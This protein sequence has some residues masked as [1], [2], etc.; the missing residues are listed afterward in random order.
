MVDIV[1]QS[2]FEDFKKSVIGKF[3]DGKPPSFVVAGGACRDSILGGQ[4]KDIDF[5]VSR[6]LD[7]YSFLNNNSKWRSIPSPTNKKKSFLAAPIGDFIFDMDSYRGKNSGYEHVNLTAMING[8]YK[9]SI[10]VQVMIPGIKHYSADDF[11]DRLIETFHFGI[12]QA[13][14][15]GNEITVSEAFQKDHENNTATLLR[16][17]HPRELIGGFEKFKRLEAK[18]PGISFDLDY[19]LVKKKKKEEIP[20]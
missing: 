15:D 13:Y 7:L 19:E 18:Y 10:P 8:W 9:E 20:F 3:S 11:G 16:V 14:Y 2:A 5:F 12:D 6:E 1:V 17:D 4:F